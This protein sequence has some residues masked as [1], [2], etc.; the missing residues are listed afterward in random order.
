MCCFLV[1]QKVIE[2][3]IIYYGGQ[4]KFEYNIKCYLKNKMTVKNIKVR[5]MNRYCN[6]KNEK[7]NNKIII[8]SSFSKFSPKEK[9]LNLLI[10]NKK[11]Y[12][13]VRKKIF[14][15]ILSD[16]KLTSIDSL[17]KY[18]KNIY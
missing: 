5:Q 9:I 8:I 15:N 16:K 1:P 7:A 10:L 13:K 6:D 3:I 11:I 2:N 12:S 17:I 18:G 14:L 4:F